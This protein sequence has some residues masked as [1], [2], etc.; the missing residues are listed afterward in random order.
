MVTPIKPPVLYRKM[1]KYTSQSSTPNRAEMAER[2]FPFVRHTFSKA[3]KD[4]KLDA[5]EIM[6][7]FYFLSVLLNAMAGY[8]LFF[9]ESKGYAPVDSDEA[10]DFKCGFSVKTGTYRFVIGILAAVTGLFKLL[11]STAGDLPFIGD[12]IP[13]ASGILSGLILFF[14]YYKNRSGSE[15]S[16]SGRSKKIDGLLIANKKLIGAAAMIASVLH[17]LFPTV[18]LL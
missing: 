11:S 9:G 12:I 15:D 10:M 16:D 8:I 2:G 5:G 17:F 1:D 14:E 6:L 18:L 4:A 3:K 7:Q 13:A